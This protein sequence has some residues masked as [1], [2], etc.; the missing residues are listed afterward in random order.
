MAAYAG[1]I[2]IMTELLTEGGDLR[3]HDNNSRTAKD[4][5]LMQPDPKK[6]LKMI[7]FLEKTRLF[8]LTQSGRDIRVMERKSSHNYRGLVNPHFIILRRKF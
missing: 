7:E 1:N 6:R 2:K 5:A 8:A 4:W 3:L